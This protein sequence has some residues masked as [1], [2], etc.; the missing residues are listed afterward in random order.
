M[1][2]KCGHGFEHFDVFTFFFEILDEKYID[3]QLLNILIRCA[4]ECKSDRS[5]HAF[6]RCLYNIHHFKTYCFAEVGFDR[7]DNDS[8]KVCQDLGQSSDRGRINIAQRS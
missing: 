6:S 2:N 3:E 7:A 5:L 1:A 8:L 4:K